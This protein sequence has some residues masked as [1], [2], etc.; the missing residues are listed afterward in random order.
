M[1]RTNIIVKSWKRKLTERNVPQLLAGLMAASAVIMGVLMIAF[2]AAYANN[3]DY[4]AV[5]RFASSQAWGTLYIIA[6]GVLGA[7]ASIERFYAQ[8]PALVLL[9]VHTGIGGLT[10]LSAIEGA[11]GAVPSTVVL[12]LTLSCVCYVTQLAC[13]GKEPSHD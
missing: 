11:T 13:S 2:P 10:L 9:A 5:L 12:Y 1:Q 4:N 7:T 8:V 3:G 6:G